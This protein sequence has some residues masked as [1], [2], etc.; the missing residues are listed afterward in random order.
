MLSYAYT[1]LVTI[2]FILSPRLEAAKRTFPPLV[3]AGLRAQP[4]RGGEC[5]RDSDS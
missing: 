5:A 2:F 3:S 4:A 1:F